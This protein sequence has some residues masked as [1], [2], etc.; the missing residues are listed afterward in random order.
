[1]VHNFEL[2]FF[3]ICCGFFGWYVSAAKRGRVPKIRGLAA[4]DALEDCVGRAAETGKPIHFATGWRGL[5]S[6][7]APVVVAGLA[8]LGHVSEL[9]GK[10]KVPIHYTAVY[11]YMIPIARDLIK[12]GYTI[13]GN[14][15]LY[16]DDMVVYTGE[17]QQSYAAA[18]QGYI[19][20]E[21]PTVNMMF[22]GMMYEAFNC[23]GAAAVVGSVQAVGSSG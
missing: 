21:K 5:D 3:V 17:Q 7:E 2:L 1:M 6:A 8:I 14:P 13:G 4:L 18:M 16:S 15:G 19:I 11:G 20:R 10:Y 23:L 12:K 22:G 9:C